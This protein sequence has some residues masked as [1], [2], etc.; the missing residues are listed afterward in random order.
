MSNPADPSDDVAWAKAEAITD[1]ESGP[2]ASPETESIVVS[3]MTAP[4]EDMTNPETPLLTTTTTTIQVNSPV[5]GL[6]R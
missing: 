5:S 1:I 2:S 4:S 6:G 3:E